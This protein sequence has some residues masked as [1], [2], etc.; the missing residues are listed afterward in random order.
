MYF[1][2]LFPFPNSKETVSS[3]LTRTDVLMNSESESA[4]K[5]CTDSI[6]KSQDGEA[7]VATDPTPSRVVFA[8]STC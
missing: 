6:Q 5:T 8:V 1:A 7:E 4:H 3:S 2:H